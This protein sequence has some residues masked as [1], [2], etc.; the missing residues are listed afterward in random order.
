ML[1]VQHLR[2][3]YGPATI[4][5]DITFLI[6]D[7]ERVGLIGPNG[8]GKTTILRCLAGQEQPD[9]GLIVMSP[10]DMAVGYLPQA[11]ADVGERTVAEVLDAAQAELRAAE[12][13]L[14]QAGEALAASQYID[15]ALADYDAA[16]ARFE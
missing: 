13:A 16:L 8:I 14:T 11:F 9:S 1:Q 2:K 3:S 4:L 7:G 5:A 10:P 15:V 12:Q 6:N